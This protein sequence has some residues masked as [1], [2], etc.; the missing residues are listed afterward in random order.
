MV[1]NV[2]NLS[3]SSHTWPSS[4]KTSNINSLPKTDN[5]TDFS[6]FRG[7]NVTPVIARCFEKI[8]YNKHS[9]ET[10]ESNL[11]IYQFAYR[12]GGCSTDALIK[13]QRTFLKSLVDKNYA[14]VR[15]LAMD[16]SKAFNNVR[17]LLL[18]HKL[19]SLPM[20]P[21]VINWYLSFL[22][23]RKTKSCFQWNRLPIYQS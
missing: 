11:S 23:N 1:T 10:F 12:T 20:N 13:L 4:W 3:L 15:I 8:V 5:P 17:H 9:K 21:Y 22:E 19:K 16:F 7:I 2:W 18:S 6:H 14:A